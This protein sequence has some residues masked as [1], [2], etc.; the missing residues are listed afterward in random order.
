MTDDPRKSLDELLAR[1]AAAREAESR[2][3]QRLSEQILA[4]LRDSAPGQGSGVPLSERPQAGR[5]G[6]GS[7]GSRRAWDTK[8]I[9]GGFASLLG[10]VLLG[11]LCYPLNKGPIDSRQQTGSVNRPDAAPPTVASGTECPASALLPAAVVAAKQQL[12]NETNAIFD[13]RLAWIADGKR[14]VVLEV[15]DRDHPGGEGFILVRVVVAQRSSPGSA[16]STVWQTDVISRHDALVEVGPENLD[17][18]SLLLWTHQ[19][20][21]GEIAVE[22]DF[23]SKSDSQLTSSSSAI[24]R[25]GE[26]KQVTCSAVEGVEC[27]VFQTA[28][29]LATS[30]I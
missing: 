10:L 23:L 3:T 27:C 29:P 11:L 14:D 19:V 12:L 22:M 30:R 25:I 9:I 26:P 17:G 5:S 16:W 13:D 7:R 1:W 20:A 24:L 4:V 15:F 18:G 2:H 21:G 6:H 28:V 8:L